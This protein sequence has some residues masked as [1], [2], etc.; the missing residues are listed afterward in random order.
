MKP[1]QYTSPPPTST[2][3]ILILSIHLRLGLPS[4]L[5][6]SEFLLFSLYLTLWSW[7]LLERSLVVWTPDCFPVFYGARRF[8]TEFTR[9]LHLSLSW[10]R[11][12]QSTSPYPT[13]TRST[14][15]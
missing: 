7:A 5:L 9:A 8:I 13:S 15:S 12:I 14:W 4:G 1:I 10:A 11:L 2:R 6:P 3:S